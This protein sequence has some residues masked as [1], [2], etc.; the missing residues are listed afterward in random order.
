MMGAKMVPALNAVN[1]L[2]VEANCEKMLR[3]ARRIEVVRRNDPA[4]RE[5]L[6]PSRLI[7]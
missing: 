3:N 2:T 1:W 4:L 7:L 5:A 6:A